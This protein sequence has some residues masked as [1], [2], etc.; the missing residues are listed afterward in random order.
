MA[1]A[2]FVVKLLRLAHRQFVQL[3]V[4]MLFAKV[5]QHNFVHPLVLLHTYGVQVQSPIVFQ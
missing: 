3:R 5:N 4:I 1:V 2:A